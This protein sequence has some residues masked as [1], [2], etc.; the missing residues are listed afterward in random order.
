MGTLAV[1][2]E[3]ASGNK[4]SVSEPPKPPEGQILME[5]KSASLSRPETATPGWNIVGHE[6]LESRRQLRSKV[7]ELIRLASSS[8]LT[9]G[10]IRQQLLLAVA[11]FGP[12]LATQLVRSLHR[13]DYQERQ[14]VVWLL[15][16][17]NDSATIPPLQRMS[18]NKRVPRAIRLSASLAL[19]GMGIT[20]QTID[21][22]RRTRLY[23][24]S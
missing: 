2:L 23:A 19:A 24:I 10:E 14:S 1:A 5:K 21:N 12:Q 15:T 20:A 18:G 13:D 8:A 3:F 9:T 4:Q 22:H 6:V 17:L 7:N 16:L 11:T